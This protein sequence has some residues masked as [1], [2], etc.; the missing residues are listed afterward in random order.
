MRG[1][2]LGAW[3]TRELAAIDAATIRPGAGY[4]AFAAP[5]FAAALCLTAARYFGGA[6]FYQAWLGGAGGQLAGLAYWAGFRCLVY[7]AIPLLLMRAMKLGRV[8]DVGFTLRGVGRHARWYALA[9]APIVLLVGLASFDPKFQRVYPFYKVESGTLAGLAAFELLYAL[10]FVGLEFFFRGF[11]VHLLAR[12]IGAAAALVAVL[13]YCMLHFTKPLPETL[14]SIVGG[15]LL[16]LLSL[17]TG[18]VAGGCLL[19]VTVAWSMDLFALAQ[20][21]KLAALLGRAAGG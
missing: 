7:F 1:A 15:T 3:I 8:R 12:R 16:G 17:R 18:S 20:A 21:G 13:P 5:I 2:A 14:A 9:L 19:H 10:Q 11:L 4:G 6:D